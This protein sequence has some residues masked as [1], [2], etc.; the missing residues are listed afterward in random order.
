VTSV[1]LVEAYLARIAAYDVDGA[2]LNAMIRLNPRARAEAVSMDAE[3]RAGRVRG[4]LHGVPVVLKDNY[5]TAD[6]PTSGGS[7][8]LATLQTPDDAFVVRRLRDAGAVIVGK[9]NMHELAA[10]ITSVSSFGGQTR[11]PYDPARC[12]GGSSGGT[13]VAVAASFA[14][15][16]WGSDTCGSIRIPSAYNSLF[17]LRP[18][19]GTVS[20]DGIIPLSHTQDIGGPLARTVTDLAIALDVTVGADSADADTRVLFGRTLPKFTDSLD[21]RA[22]RGAR[23]GVLT[24]YFAD[25]DP[26]IRDTVRS[27]IR[28]MQA[29][30]AETVEVSI[31][32]LDSLL[33]GSSAINQETKFDLMA[34]LARFPGAPVRSLHEIIEKGLYHQALEARFRLA[35]SAMVLDSDAHRRTL[36]KQAA[37][38]ARLVALLD[39]LHLDALAYPTMRQRPVL[40]GEV[41][42]GATCQLSAHSG[43]PALSAPAGFTADGLPV[44]VELIGHPFA[45][46]RLVA[47]AYAYEAAGPRRRAPF[48]APP[49]V[50]GK[51]PAPSTF[52]IVAHAG[53]TTA[54]GRFGFDPARGEL[55]W[56]LSVAGAAA[57]SVEA[58]ALRRIDE[59]GNGSRTIQR[60]SGAG[61][62]QGT[63]KLALGALDRRALAEG[64]LA[65][66]IYV[67]AEGATGGETRLRLPPVL[68]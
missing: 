40:I 34:F 61:R 44:G 53:S 6:L 19:Q 49:L 10:G 12:P 21:A 16:G 28:S 18:T 5:S 33:A 41:Q 38:R 24:N 25:A 8:A 66:A 20:R 37:L 2:A 58:V 64:R 63:G 56:R 31:A 42:L 59:A 9:T 52:T 13:G 43:L 65:L 67:G 32:D 54:T 3:R 7:I 1:E 39:S 60:L 17:G 46:V 50:R 30:G 36:G 27:A 14:A 55:S 29:L 26:E 48:T 4:P 22:L 15:V 62:L 23:L 51:A 47:M 45:D 11:N 68:R 35:D 57:G